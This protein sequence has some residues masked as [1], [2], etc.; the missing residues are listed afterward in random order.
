MI[1]K[2]NDKSITRVRATGFKTTPFIRS[3]SYAFRGIRVTFKSERNFRIQLA[4]ACVV[5]ALGVYLGLDIQKW[6]LIIF[7][8]GLVLVAE[9]FNTA[10]ERLGDE[11]AGGKLKQAVRNAKDI[12]AAAVLF[13]SLTAIIIGIMV[14]VI[15]LIHRIL[16]T[17]T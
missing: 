11:V 14:L 12:S 7:S 10:L 8:I 3:L 9:L 15:P 2:S 6:G 16:Q 5:V 17:L 4:G 13:S 1:E